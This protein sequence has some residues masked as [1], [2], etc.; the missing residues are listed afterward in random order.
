[1][2]ELAA[3]PEAGV[4]ERLGSEG[5]RLQRLARG[6]WE[7]S[8][9][10]VTLPAG[11][12]ET[13][14][15]EHPVALREP[16]LFL[17]SRLLI[18]LCARLQA[19]ALAAIQLHLR[20]ELEDGSEHLRSYKLP[21]P[22]RAPRA[23]LKLLELDLEAHPPPAAV[24]VLRLAAEPA[25]PRSL[26]HGLFLP[27]EPEPEKL[28]LILARLT[29]LVG[30][31]RVG[32]AVLLDTHRPDAFRLKR[33]LPGARGAPHRAAGTTLALRLF[34]PPLPAQVRLEE[35]RPDVVLARGVHG[36]VVEAAGPW[37]ISGDWW[38]PEAYCREEFDVALSTGG[39]YRIYRDCL[40]GGWFVAGSYD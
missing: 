9:V 17:L 36:K 20:L 37:R 8:L 21:V 23:F 11:F 27:P 38:G 6:T 28:E 10:A 31:E 40:G 1:L 16:L 24:R 3:L 34:R 14:E 39:L 22:M 15:L 33:F 35:G 25:A 2:G 32:A 12:E 13:L 30:E 4:A 26:Q 7:R 5:V 29:A 18:Q 19:R